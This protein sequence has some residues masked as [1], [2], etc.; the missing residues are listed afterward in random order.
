MQIVNNVLEYTFDLDLNN[1]ASST[2]CDYSQGL[3][4]HIHSYWKNSTV[5]S[6][7]NDYCSRSLTGNHF[8]PTFA[9]SANS[10]YIDNYCSSMNRT[11]SKGYTYNCTTSVYNAGY[12]S[13]CELGDLSSKNGIVYPASSSD[14]RFKLSKSVVD[15]Q[16]FYHRNYLNSDKNTEMWS[17]IIFHCAENKNRLVCAK[18]LNDNLDSCEDDYSSFSTTSDTSEDDD[19]KKYNDGELAAAIIVPTIVC[20]LLGFLSAYC[21]L[22]KKGDLNEKFLG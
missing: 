17:S 3:T 9:C 5:T 7:A 14:L 4:Y 20:F 18:L 2:S 21:C 10:E 22:K 13:Y 16:G 19:D 6:S 15:Y 1:F 11:S 12:Y 8:D